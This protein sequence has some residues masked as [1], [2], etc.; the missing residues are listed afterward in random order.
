MNICKQIGL[1]TKEAKAIMALEAAYFELDAAKAEYAKLARTSK[2][3]TKEQKEKDQNQAP[4]VQQK[5]KETKEKG[6]NP[7]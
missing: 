4:G 1:N 5:V 2:M 3:N 7:A 6:E